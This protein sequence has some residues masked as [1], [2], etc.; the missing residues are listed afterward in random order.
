MVSQPLWV[1]TYDA[2]EIHN[3]LTKC[4]YFPQLDFIQFRSIAN[5]VHEAFT[6]N[7]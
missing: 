7:L 6:L 2:Q 5:R 1:S 4:S 3:F